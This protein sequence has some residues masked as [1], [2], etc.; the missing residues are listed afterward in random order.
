MAIRPQSINHQSIVKYLLTLKMIS[1]YKN[2]SK[3]YDHSTGANAQLSFDMSLNLDV[4]IRSCRNG[5]RLFQ[6]AGTVILNL[7]RDRDG[8]CS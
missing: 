6:V 7:C 1:A 5:G 2:V 3:N 4:S 8:D